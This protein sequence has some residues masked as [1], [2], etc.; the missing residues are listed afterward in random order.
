MLLR[1]GKNSMGSNS[2]SRWKMF[3]FLNVVLQTGPYPALAPGTTH[4]HMY[5]LFSPFPVGWGWLRPLSNTCRTK[6]RWVRG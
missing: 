4:T 3:Q 5:A 2:V 6:I 1:L